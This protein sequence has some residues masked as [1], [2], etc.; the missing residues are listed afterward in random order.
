MPYQLYRKGGYISKQGG[1]ISLLHIIDI[2]QSYSAYRID[3]HIL[4][5]LHMNDMMHILRIFYCLHLFCDVHDFVGQTGGK[6]SPLFRAIHEI[7][8][9]SPQRPILVHSERSIGCSRLI[10]F[11]YCAY[12]DILFNLTQYSHARCLEATGTVVGQKDFHDISD[13]FAF[14]TTGT[15]LPQYCGKRHN[16]IYCI[17]CIRALWISTNLVCHPSL[18]HTWTSSCCSSGWE[19]DDTFW[20][21]ERISRFFRSFLW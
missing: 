19:R 18:L 12:F 17:L 6:I 2:Y 15:H 3:N 5:I 21:A 16:D 4:H 10:C 9:R 13:T 14:V 20:H 11:A 8:K 1:Y 7:D